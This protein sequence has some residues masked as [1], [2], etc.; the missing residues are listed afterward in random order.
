[1]SGAPV[2]YVES[3]N[4]RLVHPADTA[5][6]SEPNRR[7]LE[8]IPQVVGVGSLQTHRTS[9]RVVMRR[10]AIGFTLRIRRLQVRVLP[11]AQAAEMRF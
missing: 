2:A 4:G 8:T 11:G 5:A 3:R 1:M 9:R 6:P 7:V 10:Y